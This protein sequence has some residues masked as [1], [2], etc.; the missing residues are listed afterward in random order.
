[1][2]VRSSATKRA[3]LA[4]L[5]RILAAFAVEDYLRECAARNGRKE[6][7]TAKPHR[8]HDESRHLRP[9]LV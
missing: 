4:G 6:A 9:L 1:M 7:R 8:G 5:A 3:A 2:A